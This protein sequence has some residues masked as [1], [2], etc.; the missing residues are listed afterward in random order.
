[1]PRDI[2]LDELHIECC[3]PADEETASQ[4]RALAGSVRTSKAAQPK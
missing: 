3:F 1:M 2:T 4:C